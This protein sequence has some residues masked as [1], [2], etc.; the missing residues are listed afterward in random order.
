MVSRWWALGPPL[1][2]RESRT[3]SGAREMARREILAE[4]KKWWANQNLPRES[5]S[6]NDGFAFYGYLLRER[7]ELLDFRDA[8]D[9]WQ[10]VRVWLRRARLVTD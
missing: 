5:A 3:A 1:V 10:T 9:K 7:P 8:G 2:F 6:V 4:F